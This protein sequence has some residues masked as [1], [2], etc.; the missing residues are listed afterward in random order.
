MK[1]QAKVED[2]LGVVSYWEEGDRW[3]IQ[4]KPHIALRLKR[5][6]PKL[7]PG[8]QG[9]LQLSNTPENARDLEWFLQRYP[10]DCPYLHMLR[11]RSK[12]HR[13]QEALIA[14]LLK[15]SANGKLNLN[16]FK[17]AKPHAGRR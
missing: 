4:T 15:P 14:Q 6:F 10:H 1:L 9:I 3:L 11:E 16:G 12:T 2:P 5:V 13:E 8:E 17:M 7:R